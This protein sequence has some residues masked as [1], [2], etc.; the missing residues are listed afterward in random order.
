MQ[1]FS[2]LRQQRFALL[3]INFQLMYS[4]YFAVHIVG[5]FNKLRFQLSYLLVFVENIFD[6]VLLF[7]FPLLR[8]HAFQ[9]TV[10]IFQ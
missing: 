9:N 6:I 10:L 8:V 7:A 1:L 4:L 2:H 3:Q 5:E